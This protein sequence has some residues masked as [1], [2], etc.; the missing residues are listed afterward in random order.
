M[1][2]MR[3][4]TLLAVL[5]LGLGVFFLQ[6]SYPY[7]FWLLCGMLIGCVARDVGYARQVSPRWEI[8]GKVIAWDR[9]EELKAESSSNF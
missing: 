4:W 2:H 1:R 3:S 9:V 7:V 8:F 6:T 5:M